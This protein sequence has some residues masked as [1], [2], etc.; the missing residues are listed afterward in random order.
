MRGI[1]ISALLLPLMAFGQER[2]TSLVGTIQKIP[3]F[4]S[5]ALG[6]SRDLM[7]YLP[8]TYEAEPNR[9]FPVLYMHDGQNVFDGMTSYIPNQEW[10]ADETAEMLIRAGLI[11][12]IIIVAIP[13]AGMERGNEYLPTRAAIGANQVGGKADLY[14]KMVADE[15]KPLIDR[16]YRTKPDAKNTAVCG[17]SFGGIITLHMGMSRPNVFGKLI[18]MS[19]SIWWDNRTMITR[20]ATW[21]SRGQRL[22]LD[23]GTLEGEDSVKDTQDF[24]A[25]LSK[26]GWKGGRD[27]ACIVES[28]A[29]HNEVAW[30]GRLD[31]ALLFLFPARKD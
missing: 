15:I 17:S 16:S 1:L 24:F 26:A 12:P 30:A 29:K 13:N 18:A 10:R 11:E 25:A 4:Q 23:T 3:D 9:R 19:P 31:A 7:V 22:W 27:V 6:S 5:Q 28:G 20:A 21:K 2:K 8:P 14:T